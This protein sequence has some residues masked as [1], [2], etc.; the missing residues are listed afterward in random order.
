MQIKKISLQAF[1]SVRPAF[2]LIP[3][4]VAP[5]SAI[6]R[7]EGSRAFSGSR[8]DCAAVGRGRVHRWARNQLSDRG[9]GN[10]ERSTNSD[11]Q[12]V[13]STNATPNNYRID[14]TGGD[15]T[16]IARSSC[17]E[18][19]QGPHHAAPGSLR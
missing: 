14:W 8:S 2:G 19:T 13:I 4:A 9:A 7:R 3:G 16:V 1:S 10:S 15:L 18:A 5:H 11:N 17:D 6:S 12:K